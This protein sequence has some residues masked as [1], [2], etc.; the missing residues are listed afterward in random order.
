ML[1]GGLVSEDAANPVFR[2]GI[3]HLTFLFDIYLEGKEKLRFE[4][5]VLFIFTKVLLSKATMHL[6]IGHIIHDIIHD[7]A[8]SL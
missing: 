1:S 4:Y 5:G 8:F 7:E 6:V 2:L 3:S